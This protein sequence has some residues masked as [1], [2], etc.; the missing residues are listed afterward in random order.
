MRST[1]RSVLFTVDFCQSP[2]GFFINPAAAEVPA[3]VFGF[4]IAPEDNNR[5]EDKKHKALVEARMA[6]SKREGGADEWRR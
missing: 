1:S 5:W 4:P 3:E 6:E 2:S